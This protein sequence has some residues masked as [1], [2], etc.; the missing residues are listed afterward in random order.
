MRSTLFILSSITVAAC[1][2]GSD[3]KTPDA[4]KV[5]LDSGADAASACSVVCESHICD[6]MDGSPAPGST[7]SRG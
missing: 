7:S 2:G 4:A 1:G 5:F 6:G 3:T